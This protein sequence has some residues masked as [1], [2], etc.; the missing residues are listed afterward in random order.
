MRERLSSFHDISNIKRI[1]VDLFTTELRKDEKTSNNIYDSN[2]TVE[3]I[4]ENNKS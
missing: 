2:T 3:Q 4:R 1:H